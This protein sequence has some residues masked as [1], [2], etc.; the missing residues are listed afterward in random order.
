ML[1]IFITSTDANIGKTFVCSGLAATMQSLGYSTAVYKPIETKIREKNGFAQSMDLLAIK[2]IDPYIKTFSSYL[3]KTQASPLIAA[4]E[5]N[6]FIDRVFL[7]KDF[8]AITKECDCLITEGIEG[9]MTPLSPNFTVCDMAGLFNSPLIL[10]VNPQ[11]S[12]IN[13]TL[14]SIN[15]AERAN[16]NIRGVIIN[17]FPQTTDSLNIKAL[18]RLI[19]EY[20]NAKIL[21]ILPEFTNPKL[22]SPSDLIT[23]FLNGI[24]IESV[25]DVKIAKLDVE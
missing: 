22:L 15:Q 9:L 12:T 24:D 4:E 17:A 16:L 18:P 3:L 20:S 11:F 1:N 6:Q 19:E 23:T 8:D 2:N 21:G 10:V 14:L 5:D 13:Q 7:K 25:F